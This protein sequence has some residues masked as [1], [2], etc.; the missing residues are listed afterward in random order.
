MKMSKKSIFAIIAVAL[1][2]TTVVY[3]AFHVFYEIPTCNVSIAGIGIECY[4]WFEGE[5]L[6]ALTTEIDF[7]LL[8]TPSKGYSQQ[9]VLKAD[10]NG[11]DACMHAHAK[12][13]Y[14]DIDTQTFLRE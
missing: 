6:G 9:I 8:T 13:A 12:Y 11:V 3:A 1:L 5:T 10:C 4:D 2:T 14:S 7:G